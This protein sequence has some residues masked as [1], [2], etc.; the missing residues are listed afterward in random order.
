MKIDDYELRGM[1]Q[2]LIDFKDDVVTILN[3]GKYAN[4]VIN[5]APG[6]SGR[7]GESVFYVDTAANATFWYVYTD[8]SWT[9]VGITPAS[10]KSSINFDGNAMTVNGT[11]NNIDTVTRDANGQWTVTYGAD[12]ARTDYVCAGMCRG[13]YLKLAGTATDLRTGFSTFQTGDG[14]NPA[15]IVFMAGGEI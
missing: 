3:F 2:E 5:G 7:E 8:S 11:A 15:Q 13:T 9:S 1:P 10:L 14:S 6:W 12:F 4:M